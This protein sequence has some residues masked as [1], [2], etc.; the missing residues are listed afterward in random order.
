MAKRRRRRSH[1]N[2]TPLK[3]YLALFVLCGVAALVLQV[4]F[5]VPD[6]VEQYVSEKVEASV[7]NAIQSE[8]QAAKKE[9]AASAVPSYSVPLPR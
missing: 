6:K 9:A 3:T 2:S 1:S 7:S 5:A 8:V 4:L